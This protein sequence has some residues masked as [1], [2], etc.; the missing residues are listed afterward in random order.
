MKVIKKKVIA[1]FFKV[2]VFLYNITGAPARI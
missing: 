1:I 2:I